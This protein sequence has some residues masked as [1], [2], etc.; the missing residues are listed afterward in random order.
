MIK[1]KWNLAALVLAAA[2]LAPACGGVDSGRARYEC[3]VTVFCPD[4]EQHPGQRLRDSFWVC[5]GT[6]VENEVEAESVAIGAQTSTRDA[7]AS[8][9]LQD[10]DCDPA[11]RG[12]YD[13]C[14]GLPPQ[15]N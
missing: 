8:C 11:Y 2:L 15:P 7:D 4:T 13:I 9:A 14:G 5:G 12:P 10:Y 1:T 3:R 6:F